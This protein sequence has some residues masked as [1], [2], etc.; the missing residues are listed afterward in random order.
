M[1]AAARGLHDEEDP[2]A[3]EEDGVHVHEIAGQKR[4]GLISEK[5]TPGLLGCA[6]RCGRQAGAAQDAPD[7]GGGH[8]MAKPSQFT[9]DSDVSP[10]LSRQSLD[11]RR[12]LFRR[13]RPLDH[14]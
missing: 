1:N 13:R 3:F 11:E 9:L 2:E 10:G 4:V 12:N 8:P 6:L 7:R 5:G 14:P